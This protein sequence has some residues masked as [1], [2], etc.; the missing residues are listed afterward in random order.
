[1]PF[2]VKKVLPNTPAAAGGARAGDVLGAVNGVSVLHATSHSDLDAALER[3]RLFQSG[4]KVTVFSL[5]RGRAAPT[6]SVAFVVRGSRLGASLWEKVDND[7]AQCRG[8]V[9]VTDIAEGSAAAKA[10]ATYQQQ[11]QQHQGGSGPRM[12]DTLVAV[13]GRSLRGLDLDEVGDVVAS[14]PPGDEGREW[15]IERHPG[16][17]PTKVPYE[18][19]VTR[20]EPGQLSGMSFNTCVTPWL[21][22]VEQQGQ[23]RE[24][25]RRSI[26]WFFSFVVYFRLHCLFFSKLGGGDDLFVDYVENDGRAQRD[27]VLLGDLLLSVSGVDVRGAGVDRLLDVIQGLPPDQSK[28]FV[29]ARPKSTPDVDFRVSELFIE[30]APGQSMGIEI[31]F[32]ESYNATTSRGK[33]GTSGGGEGLPETENSRAKL[34]EITIDTA[35]VSPTARVVAGS[36]TSTSSPAGM[37]VFE[38]KYSKKLHRAM[39]NALLRQ[40]IAEVTEFISF[41]GFVRHYDP[42][43]EQ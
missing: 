35:R 30:S 2:V 3:G 28:E 31:D 16:G 42:V 7:A 26:C 5:H 1:M 21:I 38:K 11:Q 32:Q 29:V 43:L 40:K 12:W 4:R 23:L 13:D 24:L 9:Y 39:F 6:G 17:H 27:G 34:G 36:D 37:Q 20:S 15:I 19:V 22:F 25:A 33:A 10:I 41:A 14:L 8:G 18:V